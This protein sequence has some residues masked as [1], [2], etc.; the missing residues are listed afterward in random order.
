[1]LDQHVIIASRLERKWLEHD[2][3]IVPETVNTNDCDSMAFRAQLVPGGE[4]IIVLCKNGALHLRKT[5]SDSICSM[6]NSFAEVAAEVGI[7]DGM[8]MNV[9]ASDTGK[10]FLSLSIFG[11]WDTM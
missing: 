7:N 3:N 4:W 9:S 2:H 6:D 11:S 1:M 8:S 10:I 5:G